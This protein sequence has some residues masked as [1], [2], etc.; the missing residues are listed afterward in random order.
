MQQPTKSITALFITV[1]VLCSPLLALAQNL[2]AENRQVLQTLIDSKFRS[3]PLGERDQFRTPL[4]TLDFF[5]IE[6][7]LAFVEI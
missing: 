2:S 4:E 5:K 3:A 6:P 1:L 7:E